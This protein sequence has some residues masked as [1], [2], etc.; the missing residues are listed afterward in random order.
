MI[1][2][3]KEIYTN[4]ANDHSYETW[5]EFLNDSHPHTIIEATEDIM[6]EYGRRLLDHVAELSRKEL[7]SEQDIL[8]I[9]DEL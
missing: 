1:P 6:L 5:D 3:K 2:D 4:Y 7:L 8:K 9:K